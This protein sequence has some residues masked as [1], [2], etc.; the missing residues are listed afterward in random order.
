MDGIIL[1]IDGTLWD[2]TEV[3]VT[4]WNRAIREQS[5]LKQVVTAPQLKR[6]FGKPVEKILEHVFPTLETDARNQL[7]RYCLEYE[8][9]DARTGD[10]KVYAG[11][12]EVIKKLS[13]RYCICIV[14][15]CMSGYIEAFLYNTKLDNYITDYTCPGDTGMSKAENI[16]LIKK[17]NCLEKAIY[18]GDTKGDLDACKEAGITMIYANYG[19]GDLEEVPYT[20]ESFWEL[21]KIDMSQIEKESIA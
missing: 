18:V 13:E 20:I 2:S 8:N 19:F 16:L 12:C 9:V 15:N 6:E 7:G 17:R 3:V 14:S 21:L 11:V 4:A 1:D 10:C 5:N